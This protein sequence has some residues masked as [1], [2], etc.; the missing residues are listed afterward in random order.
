ML[1][2]ISLSPSLPPYKSDKF[3]PLTNT[4]AGDCLTP[5]TRSGTNNNIAAPLMR[6]MVREE[7]EEEEEVEQQDHW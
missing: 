3:N 7:E 6:L 2:L 5:L 4:R 1:F